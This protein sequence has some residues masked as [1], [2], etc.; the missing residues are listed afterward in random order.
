MPSASSVDRGRID[1]YR[2]EDLYSRMCHRANPPTGPVLTELAG[3]AVLLPAERRFGVV[4]DI[5][6]YLRALRPAVVDL[7]TDDV[8]DV[9]VRV[10]RGP[11]RAHWESPGTIA[12]PDTAEMRREHVV[13]HELA[14]HLDHHNRDRPAPAHGPDFRTV[15][16]RLH[17][18]ATGPVGGWALTVLFDQHLN[19]TTT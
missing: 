5:D 17:T 11:G 2:C 15:L 19:L 9:S 13:L 3:S 4:S 6:R 14:H 1:V 12:I 10:R 18:A 7:W 8:P 16:C